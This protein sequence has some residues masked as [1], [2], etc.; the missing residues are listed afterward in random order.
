V[1]R[2]RLI[3]AVT[4]R[5]SHRYGRPEWDEE[6]NREVFGAQVEPHEHEWR[7]EVRVVGP[8]DPETGWVVD[9]RGLDEALSSLMATWHGSELNREIPEVRSGG[10]QPS[11][12]NLARW[13]FLKLQAMLPAETTL[14][15]VRVFED[16]GL[17]ASFPA[18]PGA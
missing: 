1:D 6:R 14:E 15:E 9:L 7:L 12:E 13:I 18:P 4:F 5:A 16:T 3:R 11:T 10:A 2:A 17:G 8:I